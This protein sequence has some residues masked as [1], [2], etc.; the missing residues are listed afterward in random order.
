MEKKKYICEKA[1][2]CENKRCQ[3][4]VPHEWN[5]TQ[6][7][8]NGYISIILHCGKYRC[9]TSGNEVKCIEYMGCII[10][11]ELFEI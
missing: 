4:I 9:S 5:E 11:E 3:H 7:N 8:S 6:Y 2:E 10:P 1:R